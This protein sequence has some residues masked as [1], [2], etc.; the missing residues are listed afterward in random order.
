ML[1]HAIANGVYVA[2]ANRVG[3]ERQLEFWG[4]SFVA[5]PNG[6]VLARAATEQRLHQVGHLGAPRGLEGP[7]LIGDVRMLGA[8]AVEFHVLAL[9]LAGEVA[10]K[11]LLGFGGAA[12]AVS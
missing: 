12:R 4:S 7:Q 6:N 11:G 2:A 3:T 8:E 1:S 10:E 9:S 5:D